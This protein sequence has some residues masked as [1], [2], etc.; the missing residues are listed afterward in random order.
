MKGRVAWLIWW[1]TCWLAVFEADGSNIRKKRIY[2]LST[3]AL[4]DVRRRE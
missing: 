4:S 1:H 2:S 3:W